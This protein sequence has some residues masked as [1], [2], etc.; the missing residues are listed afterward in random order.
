MSYPE[1]A[2]TLPLHP[3]ATLLNAHPCGLLAINK[4]QNI[5]SH[6]ND[7]EGE[8]RT[9]IRAPYDAQQ[10]AYILPDETG[11]G[12]TL[13]HLLNRLDSPTSGVLL[14]SLDARIAAE[15]R[16]EFRAHRV[17]KTYHAIVKGRPRPAPP[18]WR[19]HLKRARATGG[20]LRAK[21]GSG[22]QCATRIQLIKP[23]ANKLGV[24]LITLK[25]M[26]GRTH[27]L[28]VQ[29]AQRRHHIVGDA[30]YG[31]FK[32]NT[33]I[34]QLTGQ[35]RLFLHASHTAL[36]I[37]LDGQRIDFA[38]DASLPPEFEALLAFD[39]TIAGRAQRK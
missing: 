10:E 32:F 28:R 18:V 31:D 1:L 9:V 7:E 15:V 11:D 39:K 4:P 14:F 29:C 24:T 35:K 37:R 17:E 12:V 16:K 38:A 6:P 13:L 21:A 22:A 5:L 8:L 26:T 36:T 33:F 20:A 3:K 19:D 27:Q 30:N 34:K 25:P 2:Q 23:D